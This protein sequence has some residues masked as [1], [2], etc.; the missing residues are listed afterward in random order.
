MKTILVASLNGGTQWKLA[1]LVSTVTIVLGV[2]VASSPQRAANIWGSQ[3][4]ANLAPE[5]RASFVRRWYRAF[6]IL[7]CLSGVL[8]ALESIVSSNY[9]H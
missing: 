6:G 5:R 7:L 3:R 9:Y 1:V 2:F 8:L 4:L